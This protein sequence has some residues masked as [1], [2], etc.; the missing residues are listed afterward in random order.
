MTKMKPKD[1]IGLKEVPLVNQENYPLEYTL[2]EDGLY[3]Y[4]LKP[5][6]EHNNQHRRATD[7]TWSKKVYR[8]SK[9][10]SSLSNQVM[11]HLK[12]GLERVFVEEELMLIPEDTDYVTDYVKN[13]DISKNELP[14]KRTV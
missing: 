13:G 1:V 3:C 14:N 4:L 2:L 5:G 10:I 6:E 8:L 7:R 12:D 9:V 11:Y